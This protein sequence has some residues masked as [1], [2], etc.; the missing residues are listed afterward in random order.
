MRSVRVALA[1]FAVALLG[2]TGAL[3]ATAPPTASPT[4][5]AAPASDSP[6]PDEPA[7]R[8]H[9]HRPGTDVDGDSFAGSLASDV[10]ILK[11]N[12]TLHSDPKIDRAIAEASESSDP[13]TLTADE[14]DVDRATLTYVAKGHVHF[15]QGTR[16]GDAD[17]AMLNEGAHTIDLIGN[18]NVV[19]GDRRTAADKMHY[20]TVDKQF[21]AAG[22]VRI[23]QPLP[24]PNPDAVA[25]AA[26]KKRKHRLPL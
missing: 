5:A 22:D 6:P 17:T 3:G 21:A 8:A 15:V 14:I 9:F 12:V 2:L 23:Y 7:G 10:F 18:A 19:D 4:P 13:L 1:G 26:P 16:S 24:T 11:G 20:D 25:S